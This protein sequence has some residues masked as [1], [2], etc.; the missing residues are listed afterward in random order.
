LSVIKGLH[1]QWDLTNQKNLQSSE[2]FQAE[3]KLP[4][5]WNNILISIKLT[6]LHLTVFQITVFMWYPCLVLDNHII[7][8][9]DISHLLCSSTMYQLVALLFK[10]A[11]EASALYIYFIWTMVQL[12]FLLIFAFVLG[13]SSFQTTAANG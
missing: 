5:I 3:W 9:L 8:I 10:W 12:E 6:Q 2:V 13:F 1:D 11:L 4:C 7:F